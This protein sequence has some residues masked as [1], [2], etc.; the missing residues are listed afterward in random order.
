MNTNT[1]RA[2]SSSKHE[3]VKPGSEIVWWKVWI[4]VGNL[5]R[6][7]LSV[8]FFSRWLDAVCGDLS[9]ARAKGSERNRSASP[10]GRKGADD[11]LLLKAFG[12]LS[13]RN[14]KSVADQDRCLADLSGKGPHL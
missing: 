13:R 10:S 7:T 6:R 1:T 9:T 2:S 12:T 4:L 11:S 5:E 3:P 14:L 8:I